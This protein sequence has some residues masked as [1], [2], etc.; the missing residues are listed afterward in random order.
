MFQA[1]MEGRIESSESSSDSSSPY[2]ANFKNTFWKEL[3]AGRVN[4]FDNDM[5]SKVKKRSSTLQQSKDSSDSS[6]T[7]PERKN[8]QNHNDLEKGSGKKKV[9]NSS[10]KSTG[11]KA[12]IT[13][14]NKSG[15][16]SESSRCIDFNSTVSDTYTDG[17]GKQNRKAVNS[18]KKETTEKKKN[19]SDDSTDSELVKPSIHLVMRK[20]PEI[21]DDMGKCS[22]T[23]EGTSSTY[24][25]F[26][27]NSE[28]QASNG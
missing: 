2:P 28:P 21:T 23:A 27:K 16:H 9:N 4:V 24:R 3:E 17:T 26:V 10:S 14:D 7:R 12:K 1:M 5:Y 6:R 19:L 13:S 20:I 18:Q 25:V 8:K 11:K 22:M 15:K